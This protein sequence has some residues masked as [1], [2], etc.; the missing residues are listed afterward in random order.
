MPF[1]SYVFPIPLFLQSYESKRPLTNY[2]YRIPKHKHKY[3]LAAR[4]GGS[5][6]VDP[7]AATVTRTARIGG[8]G[9]LVKR[10]RGRV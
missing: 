9:E 6:A 8:S 5:V 10:L 7:G 3:S 2:A 4:G 1:Q